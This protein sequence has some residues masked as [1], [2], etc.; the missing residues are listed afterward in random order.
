MKMLI[1]ESVSKSA[2]NDHDF[3][4]EIREP[5][6]SDG[7][8][9]SETKGERRQRHLFC[10]A[11]HRIKVERGNAFTNLP[12]NGEKKRDGKAMREHQNRR[13]G[14]TENIRTGDA[15]K[16]VAHVHDTGIAEHPVE[17]AVRDRDQTDVND[18]RQEKDQEQ[19]RPVLRSV[20]QE[21]QRDPE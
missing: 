14:S 7:S 1:I 17:P 3:A 5:R 4:R 6:E 2:E 19:S 18:V 11:A 16:N 8:E 15:E 20:G 13:A 21:W 10:Q 9:C 12:G